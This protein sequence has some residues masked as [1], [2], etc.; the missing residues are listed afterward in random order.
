MK[1][2]RVELRIEELVL[3]GFAPQ[4]RYAIGDALERELMRL[5]AEEGTP[6]ALSRSGE[7]ERI[8]SGDFTARPG[9]APASIG[10]QAAQAI[11][12]GFRR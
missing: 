10:V 3:D 9:A 7:I 11:Y 4:D 6:A 2:S 1:P 12:R 8:D 5:L